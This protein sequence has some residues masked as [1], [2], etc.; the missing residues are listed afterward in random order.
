MPSGRRRKNEA[1]DQGRES[2]KGTDLFEQAVRKLWEDT[3]RDEIDW[4]RIWYLYQGLEKF[5]KFLSHDGQAISP[6]IVRMLLI[7][8]LP[9]LPT[10]G[11]FSMP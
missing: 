1:G 10:G 3:R 7:P 8:G 6:E 5:W 9:F 2:E 4:E 11:C